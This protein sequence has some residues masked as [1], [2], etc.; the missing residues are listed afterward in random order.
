MSYQVFARK[1]RPRT[2]EDILGQDHVVRTLRNA[3]IKDRIA[4]AYLF[5]GPRGTGKTSTARILAKALNCPEGPKADFDPNAE[6]CL[7][8]AEGRSLDVLEIDGAS[9]NGVEQVRE[10]R[11]TVQYSPAQGRYKIY[12][13]DE[14][15]MLTNQAFNALLKTLE[16]PPPHVKFIFATTEPHKILPTIISRCQRFDLRRIPDEVIAQHLLHI[17]TEENVALSDTAAAAI[18]RGAEGGMR[19]AQSMLDQ[20]V[21]FCGESIQE[22]DVEEIFGI[23]S[24]ETIAQLVEH[25]LNK[26]SAQALSAIQTHYESGQDLLRLLADLV[27]YWRNLIVWQVDGGESLQS[28]GKTQREILAKQAKLADAEHLLLAVEELSSTLEKLRWASDQKLQCD[29]GL[30][31]TIRSLSSTSLD[32]VLGFLQQQGADPKAALPFVASNTPSA[33]SPNN[34]STSSSLEESATAP[35]PEITAEIASPLESEPNQQPKQA[36]AP[37]FEN[38]PLHNPNP[39]PEEALDEQEPV[40]DDS[41]DYTGSLLDEFK[42][43][44]QQDSSAQASTEKSAP[45][46]NQAD[47]VSSKITLTPVALNPQNPQQFWD[48]FAQ[49]LEQYPHLQFIADAAVLGQVLKLEE[50]KLTI[51]LPPSKKITFEK[52]LRPPGGE[53]LEI[54]ATVA[55]KNLQLVFC[56]DENIPEVDLELPPPELVPKKKEPSPDKKSAPKTSSAEVQN[57]QET[58]EAKDPE[59]ELALQIFEAE[60][61]GKAE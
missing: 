53:L 8:I 29:L 33:T 55:G 45:K 60:V 12:Y 20:L 38:T 23:T 25:L 48:Q 17:A 37:S 52:Y 13:I 4:Q 19:D 59:I 21:A 28:L 56:I 18:A 58:T 2:F 3:I 34:T 51:G 54:L 31:R 61:L 50:D 36:A 14:V 32:N 22:T 44:L 24:W 9:N 42:K 35:E 47:E 46:E 39:E 7:E 57:A 26:R 1:Y 11:E 30:V 27:S 6:I 43:Q 16:E 40:Y 49:Q 10:L 5:V 41:D 15:H